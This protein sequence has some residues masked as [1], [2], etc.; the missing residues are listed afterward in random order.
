MDYLRI[1]R[2]NIYYLKNFID[3]MG[4]SSRSFRY[5]ANRNPDEVIDNHLVTYILCDV[6]PVGYGHLD[7]ENEKVWLGVCVIDGQHGKGYGKMIMEKLVDSYSGDIWLSVD[8]DNVRAINLYKLFSFNIM[9][10]DDTTV[11]MKRNA[12]SI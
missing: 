7:K 9:S 5:Y 10:E 8:V 2:E 1:N 4:T 3:D 11:Y 12:T 6:D